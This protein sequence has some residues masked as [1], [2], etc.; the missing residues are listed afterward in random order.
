[1]PHTREG[2][3]RNTGR[4]H[5]KKG[6][7]PW[8]K[9]KKGVMPTP[10]NKGTKGVMKAW[11]K[12][13]KGTQK[14]NIGSFKKGRATW[15]KGGKHSDETLLKMRLIKLGKP[16]ARKGKKYPSVQGKNHYA[17]KGDEVSYSPLHK[18]VTKNLG[19]P[20]AC[21]FCGVRG[22]M[23]GNKRL[24][25]NIEHANIS[26]RYLR[27]LTDWRSLCK[28]CHGKLDAQERAIKKIRLS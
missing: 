28:P 25:W 5:F 9:G 27:K 6:F 19:R 8:N 16:S 21:E 12:G 17:W 26:G 2:E 7:T 1:M 3:R 15:N 11:N 14:V 24:R 18:W 20:E 23:T 4:T 13:L 10:W 22:R